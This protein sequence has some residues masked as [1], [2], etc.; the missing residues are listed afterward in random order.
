MDHFI[1]RPYDTSLQFLNFLLPE[2]MIH[3]TNIKER[4]AIEYTKEFEQT[5]ANRGDN[6]HIS[7]RRS[8]SIMLEAMLREHELFGRLLTSLNVLLARHLMISNQEVS[9]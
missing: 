3:T 2:M 4:L 6:S 5:L 8:D 1:H 7:T 9:M